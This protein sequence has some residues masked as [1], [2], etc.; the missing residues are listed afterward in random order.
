MPHPFFRRA[1]ALALF[2]AMCV[3]QAG[4]PYQYFQLGAGR[5]HCPHRLPDWH[6]AR[7][8]ASVR[9]A[10]LHE[11]NSAR[12]LSTSY[13]AV[14]GT[15]VFVSGKHPFRDCDD[16]SVTAAYELGLVSGR[17]DGIFDPDSSIERQDLMRHAEQYSDRGKGRCARDCG[18]GLH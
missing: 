13:K 15:A 12:S 18:R 4:A 10:R 2:A 1:G 6:P 3:P 7:W 11:Q 9:A 17:G 16:P 14:S 5:C 8:T